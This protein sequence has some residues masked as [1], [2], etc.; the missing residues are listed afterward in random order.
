MVGH[1]I[2]MGFDPEHP[3]CLSPIIVSVLLRQ[4]LGFGGLVLTDDLAMGAIVKYYA[5]ERVIELAL[6]AG[7]SR[8]LICH[9]RE[10]QRRAVTHWR[11][12][13]RRTA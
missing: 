4:R 5:I 3:S 13:S 6:R 2:M 10:L 1:Q 8:T 9:N 12:L 11:D 7:C